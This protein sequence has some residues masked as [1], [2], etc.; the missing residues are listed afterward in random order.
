MVK[1]S[2]YYKEFVDA[3]FIEICDFLDQ[4]GNFIIKFEKTGLENNNF[5]K[6]YGIICAI[7]K[8]WLDIVKH[9]GVAEEVEHDDE[10]GCV[11]DN[12]YI[13]LVKIES[14]NFYHHFNSKKFC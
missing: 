4:E 14:S 2:F 5:L 11:V 9:G 8:K 13:P 6:W 7:P 1:K 12:A 10:L 3:G